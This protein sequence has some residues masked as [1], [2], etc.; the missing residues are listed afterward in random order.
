VWQGRWT[1]SED[2]NS[3][4]WTGS[5]VGVEDCPDARRAPT[6]NSAAFAES[7]MR[8][9]VKGS[10]SSSSSDDKSGFWTVSLTQGA[11]WDLGE[12]SEKKRHD[13][14]KHVLYMEFLPDGPSEK[15]SSIVV[16]TGENEF[17]SF[18]SA[19]YVQADY[20][21]GMI[22]HD[23]TWTKVTFVRNGRSK[24]CTNA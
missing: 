16:A 24:N 5:W 2:K 9:E 7:D 17:G 11:G 13:D 1:T 20:R 3:F 19:G 10:S 22:W 15:G 12:G 23:A 21:K 14:H 6:P 8:F 18:I 4:T